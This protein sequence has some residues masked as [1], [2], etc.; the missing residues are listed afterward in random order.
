M[1]SIRT[2]AV[3]GFGDWNYVETDP[4]WQIDLP[5]VFGDAGQDVVVV[6]GPVFSDVA[7]FDPNGGVFVGEAY[8]GNGVLGEDI[9][10][11]FYFAVPDFALVGYQVLQSGG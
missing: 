2:D 1:K 9:G 10:M 4:G 6:D 7:V 5:I 8:F 3:C 11:R